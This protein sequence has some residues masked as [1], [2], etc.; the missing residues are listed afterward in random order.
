[1]ATVPRRNLREIAGALWYL[2]HPDASRE[3]LRR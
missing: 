2:E 3:E 1:M